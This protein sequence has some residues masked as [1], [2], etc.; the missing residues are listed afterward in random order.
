MSEP[1]YTELQVFHYPSMAPVFISSGP[2]G[3]TVDLLLSFES[4]LDKKRGRFEGLQI[5]PFQ[6][7]SCLIELHEAM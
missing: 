3:Q 4:H 7:G 2:L 6:R 5:S 1:E